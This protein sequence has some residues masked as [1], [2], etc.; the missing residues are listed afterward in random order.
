MKTEK[1][2]IIFHGWA[3]YFDH[4]SRIII[5]QKSILKIIINCNK[6]IFIYLYA[7]FGRNNNLFMIF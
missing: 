4:I 5:I 1:F 7:F 2:I 3:V 6:Q